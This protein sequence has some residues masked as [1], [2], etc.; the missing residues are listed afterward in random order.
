VER[1]A[2]V[3]IVDDIEA[4]RTGLAKLLRLRGYDTLE[5]S[6]GNEALES[7]KAHPETR[8]VILDLRMPGGSGYRFREEQLR[9]P[10]IAGVPVV[11]FTGTEDVEA[12]KQEL[13]VA[14]VLRKPI[15]VDALL[16]AVARWAGV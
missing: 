8:V 14:D 7:L 13:L 6:N 1:R 15:S 10:A 2:T 16:E 9:E 11:V 3:L 4:T 5:A 12:I